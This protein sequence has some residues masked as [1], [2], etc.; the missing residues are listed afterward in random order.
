MTK[1]IVITVDGGLVDEVYNL[2]KG[3][4]PWIVDYD[5]VATGEADQDELDDL[6][7]R[8]RAGEQP[9]EKDYEY[10]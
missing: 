9:Q 1:W 2:P 6:V 8:L 10:G 4:E 7:R 3:Y 5:A